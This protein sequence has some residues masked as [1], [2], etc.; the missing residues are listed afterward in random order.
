MKPIEI[1]RLTAD[2]T[3]RVAARA[4]LHIAVGIHDFPYDWP[5]SRADLLAQLAYP[6]P[7]GDD[8]Y[9]LAYLDGALVGTAH[10]NLPQLDNTENA[11]VDVLVHH[12]H[13]RAGIGRQLAE[14]TI[15]RARATD[16]DG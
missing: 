7:G 11:T 4:D 1:V 12:E 2:D 15:E 5:H 16:D 3:A 13:R 9:W 6:F 14:H 10:V 8:E